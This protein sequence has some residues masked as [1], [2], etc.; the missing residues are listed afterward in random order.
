M[1][2]RE[3]CS[4]SVLVYLV[5][6]IIHV[7][8]Q[9]YVIAVTDLNWIIENTQNNKDKL[10]ILNLIRTIFSSLDQKD[11]QKEVEHQIQAFNTANQP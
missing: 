1:V 2:L 3:Y 6:S 5:R 11:K 7:K 9:K 8:H 4:D 10:Q